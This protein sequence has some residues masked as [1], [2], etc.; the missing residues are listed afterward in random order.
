MAR[1]LILHHR[2]LILT[3]LLLVRYWLLALLALHLTLK[4]HVSGNVGF[5]MSVARAHNANDDY[6]ADNAAY[7]R[8]NDPNNVNPPDSSI[9]FTIASCFTNL[10]VIAAVGV[11]FNLKVAKRAVCVPH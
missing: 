1:L 2:L 4:C 7:D 10:C 5:C 3:R 9:G 8:D 6:Y 11:A